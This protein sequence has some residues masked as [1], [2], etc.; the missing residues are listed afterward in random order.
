MS[1]KKQQN[2]EAAK[3]V[4]LS[5]TDDAW[6]DY[7]Y[8]QQH[9]FS[10]VLEINGLLEECRRTPFKGTGKPEPL[11]GDLTG[12]WSRRIDK[13]N[14]LVYLPEDNSIYVVQCRLHY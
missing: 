13:E 3:N 7:L 6:E 11:K 9:D 5:W 4:A 12:D 8:W 1:K 14:R 2:K 10:K